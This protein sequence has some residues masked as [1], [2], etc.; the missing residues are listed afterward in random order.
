MI[1]RIQ[2]VWLLLSGLLTLAAFELAFFKVTL[3]DSTNQLYYAN[4]SSF[5][6]YLAVVLLAVVCFGTI[7]L[8]KQRPLQLRLCVLGIVLA[9]ALLVLENHQIDV[10][11][12]AATYSDGSFR[13]GIALPILVIIGLILA[14]RGIRKDQKLVKSLDRLR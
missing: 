9:I 14:M 8:F 10:V 12:A 3:K 4:N 5:L 6:V 1:Q 7:F 13:A 11:K 2:T